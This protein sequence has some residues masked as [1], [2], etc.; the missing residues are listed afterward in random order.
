MSK[1]STP[2]EKSLDSS[3]ADRDNRSRQLNPEHPVYWQERGL[4]GRPP[5]EN[6]PDKPKK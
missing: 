2:S 4:P 6:L 1:I 5:E 3:K